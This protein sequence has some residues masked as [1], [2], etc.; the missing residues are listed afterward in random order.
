MSTRAFLIRNL[1]I[2][3]A[4]TTF[5]PRRTIVASAQQHKTVTESVKAAA[6]TVDR[7]VSEAAIKGLEGVEKVN[8]IAKDA[9]EK[10]GIRTEKGVNELEVEGKAAATKAQAKGEQAKRD[11]KEG[12]KDAADK[13]KDAAR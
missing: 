9:A 7:T 12:I 1:P 3:P 13:V 4:S 8:A 2:A 6:K 11:V 10:V 5:L